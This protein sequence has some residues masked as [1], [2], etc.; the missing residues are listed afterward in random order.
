MWHLTACKISVSL[1]FFKWNDFL[2]YLW[3]NVA[4]INLEIH[5]RLKIIFDPYQKRETNWNFTG[6]QVSHIMIVLIL[7]INLLNLSWIKKNV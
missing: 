1:S 4:N 7:Y 6:C 2:S 3:I 5:V